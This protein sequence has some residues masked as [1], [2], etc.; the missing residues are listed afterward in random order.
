MTTTRPALAANLGFS[1][2]LLFP[3]LA[4][5]EFVWV[6]AVHARPIATGL[7]SR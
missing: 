7:G 2:L 1:V 6:G 5:Q 3:P 4:L